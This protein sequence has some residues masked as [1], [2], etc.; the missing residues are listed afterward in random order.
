[1][2]INKEYKTTDR[3]ENLANTRC[4]LEENIKKAHEAWLLRLLDWAI[5]CM[6]KDLNGNECGWQV[7]SLL[8]STKSKCKPWS[9]VWYFYLHN[10]DPSQSIIITEWEIDRLTGLHLWWNFIGTQGIQNLYTLVEWLINKWV[11]TFYLLVDKDDHWNREIEKLNDLISSWVEICD[12]RLALWEHK[13]LNEL[14]QNWDVLDVETILRCSI[15]LRTEPI[16]TTEESSNDLIIRIPD[17]LSHSLEASVLIDQYTIKAC[18]WNVFIYDDKRSI[19]RMVADDEI[20]QIIYNHLET[21][22]YMVK[23][24][25]L[26]NILEL[27]K[28]KS[29][30]K[31]L[32]EK[33]ANPNEAEFS[34]NISDGIYDVSS[35]EFYP[36]SSKQLVFDRLEFSKKDIDPIVTLSPTLRLKTLR[37][38]LEWKKDKESIILFLQEYI[39]YCLSNSTKYEKWLIIFWSGNNGKS[40]IINTIQSILG[41]DSYTSIGLWE[42]KS[43]QRMIELFGKKALIDSDLPHNIQ[44]DASHIKK[45]VSGESVSGRLLY[46]NLITFI[47]TAKILVATNT[48]PRIKNIDESVKRR[49]IF[50]KLLQCFSWREDRELSQ[51]LHHER[52][53]IFSRAVQGLKRL[54]NRWGFDIPNELQQ[55]I[56]DVVRDSDVIQDFLESWLVKDD[57]KWFITNQQLFGAYEIFRQ[58]NGYSKLTS[59]TIS[60]RL[61]WKWYQRHRT[62]TDRWISWLSMTK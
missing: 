60:S 49:F 2:I 50:I 3:Y 35:W 24:N 25:D 16:E 1:M 61:T 39:W 28:T 42:L 8:S 20:K 17:K 58:T 54:I 37:E 30:S 56:D 57:E 27:I 48:L 47:P 15:P 18:D 55:E 22:W 14:Y 41:N 23:V 9:K 53:A 26:R 40:V 13:D 19:Y 12:C 38:I 4:I 33:L 51:K 11:K 46:K 59:R 5:E 29:F 10:I 62:G 31:S 6:M 34:I 45:I 32:K 7:R 21:V 36:K 52:D 43:D 44:L